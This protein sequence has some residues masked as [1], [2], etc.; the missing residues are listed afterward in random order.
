MNVKQRTYLRETFGS[1]VTFDETERKLYG[2]DIAAIPKL[3]KPL[4]GNTVPEAVVQPINEAELIELV[5]WARAQN[6]HLT[7]RGKASSGYGGVIPVKKGLVVDFYRMKKV[8]D[9]DGEV[10]TVTVEPGI[11]W[12]KLDKELMRAGLT[13]RLYPTSYPSSSVGGWLAQ[14]GAGIGSYEYGYFRDNVL[15]ARV[16]LPTGDVREFTRDDLELIADAEGITGMISR[17]TLSVQPYEELDVIALGCP[18]AHDLQNLIDSII[19]NK[20]PIWSMLFIN[21]RMAEMKNRAPLL[22]HHGHPVEPRVQ[23]PASYVTTIA[24]RAKDS[25]RVRTA[26]E[27]LVKQCEAEILSDRI[28]HHEWE[29]RFKL[30][31]VKRLG[32]SLVPA[33]VIVPLNSLGDVMTEIEHKVNQPV[34]K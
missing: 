31:V 20:L 19:K 9:I 7:P 16:V 8:F 25:D 13:L 12:E 34:V 1:R 23:L 17:V 30:M 2:H 3:I 10:L 28:A 11:T 4:I 24:F 21:P 22:E 14:G 18:D 6:I 15:S 5:R 26:L 29:H 27:S 33:E 32:P